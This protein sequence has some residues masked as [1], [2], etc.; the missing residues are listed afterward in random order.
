M[1]IYEARCNECGRVHEYYQTAE[2]CRE[3]PVC[4]DQPTEKVILTAPYGVVDIPAYVSP[5]SGKWINSRRDRAEDLKRTD[6]RPWEG[7]EQEK[8]EAARRQAYKEA[9]EDKKLEKCITETLANMPPEKKESLGV[10]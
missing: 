7:L 3:T 5:V 9:E 4:C 6:S 8:K 1:P 2:R 10:L